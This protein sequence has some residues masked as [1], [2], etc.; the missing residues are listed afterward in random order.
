MS[1]SAVYRVEVRGEVVLL[2][3]GDADEPLAPWLQR[4]ATQRLAAEAGLAPKVLHVN[5]EQ[6]AVVSE[7]VVDQSFP[8]F[9]WHPETHERALENLGHTISLVHALPILPDARPQDP[10]DVLATIAS[11]LDDAMA[12]PGFVREALGRV[13]AEEPP[14]SDRA[15]VTSHNDF[16]PTNVA[17][18]GRNLVVLDWDT[19]APNDPYYDL[20]AIS[21]FMRMDDD[22]CLRLLAAYDP[23]CKVPK[24]PERYVWSRRFVSALSGAACLSA[25]RKSG[26]RGEDSAT[27]S[28]T[29]GLGDFYQSL[30]SGATSLRGADGQWR[31]GLALMRT[32]LEH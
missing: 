20:A 32:S 15:L 21:I 7:F 3:I 18:D 12:L 4:L 28:N 19:T 6:R 26:H 24:M 14:P 25:A 16:N 27:I 10:R 31:F 9:Y 2:K 29:A 23:S 8:R 22:T 13:R 1:G 17:Y 11:R 5:A 30:Q